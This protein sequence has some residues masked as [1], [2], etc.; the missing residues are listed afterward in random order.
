VDVLEIL[1]QAKVRGLPQPYALDSARVRD[2]GN[3]EVETRSFPENCE[4]A[5]KAS[6]TYQMEK[7]RRFTGI[8]MLCCRPLKGAMYDAD[9]KLLMRTIHDAMIVY[10]E[11][12]QTS[13]V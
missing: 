11:G 13:R 7:M 12:V 6:N 3:L 9:P 1:L 2:D 10:C 4:V 5:L 8:L